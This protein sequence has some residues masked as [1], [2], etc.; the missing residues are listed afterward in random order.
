MKKEG[1]K[2]KQKV[3]ATKLFAIDLHIAKS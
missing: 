1:A 2:V 3:R